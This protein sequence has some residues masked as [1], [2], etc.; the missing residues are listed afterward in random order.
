MKECKKCGKCCE[1]SGPTLH[2]EDKYLMVQGK[3]PPS[4]L[5]TLRKGE[6]AFDPRENR[7]ITLENELI[8]IKGKSKSW[9]CLYLDE[10]SKLCSIYDSRPVECRILKCWDTKPIIAMMNKNLLTREVVFEKIEGL[11]QLIKEHDKKCSYDE[12]KYLL[13]KIETSEKALTSLKDIILFDINIREIVAEKQ[14]AASYMLDL[15][16][17]RSLVETMNQLKYKVTFSKESG[18]LISPYKIDRILN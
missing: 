3:I 4:D 12:I 17:G 9:T 1:K 7:A 8:K 6:T 13:E 5:V 10:E 14:K 15:I 11:A 16:F 18:L 2:I